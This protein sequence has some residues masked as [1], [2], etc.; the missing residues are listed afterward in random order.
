[1]VGFPMLRNV[2]V[3]LV[4]LSGTG[5]L[6][7]ARELALFLDARVVDNHWINNPIF[8]LI[9]NDRVTPFPTGVWDQVAK[10]RQA[11]LDTIATLSAPDANFVLTHAGH[12]DDRKD[13]EIYDAIARTAERRASVFVPVRLLCEEAELMR[14]VVSPE[15][16]SRLKSMDPQAASREARTRDVLKVN[17]ANQMTLDIS[18]IGPQETARLIF[19]HIQARRTAELSRKS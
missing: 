19:E 12:D 1:M 3:Y 7:V 5:K 11:V 17:H 18:A 16:A 2:M 4:G 8:G 6:T 9:E 15:R 10:V 14:R 13:W